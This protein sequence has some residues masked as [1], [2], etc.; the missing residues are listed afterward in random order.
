[1][2]PRADRIEELLRISRKESRAIVGLMS[3]TSLDGIDAALCTVSGSGTQTKVELHAFETLK[4]DPPLR[5]RL[6]ETMEDGKAVD[7]CEVDFLLGEALAE[8]VGSVVE[9]AGWRLADVDLIASHGQT[10]WHVD[11][12]H[13]GVPST[14]QVGQ[15][16]VIAERTGRIVVA[17][18]RPRDIAAGGAGAPLVA[19]VDHCLFSRPG[20][21]LLLQNVGGMANVTVVP[22]R[23]EDA[24]AF[25]TGPGN[26]LID[27]V[28]R[29]LTGDEEAC[30][31]DGSFSVLGEVDAGLLDSLLDHPYL[32]LPAPKTTGRE[33]FGPDMARGLIED[34]RERLID[35]VAT[36]VRFT[37]V[38]IARAYRELILPLHPPG[39][40]QETIVS[41][42]GARNPTLMAWL[43]DEL[44][45]DG[46]AVRSFDTLGVG[47]SA[48]AK[49]A[50]AFAVLANETIQGRPS[51]LPA[52]T[53][54]RRPAVLGK[55]VL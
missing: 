16:A 13:D 18:F 48:D 45:P 31:R 54:A 7:V 41:G 40:I 55:I 4:F 30:D 49:E 35:L 19:Y 28:C 11:R 53:G 1:V 5:R 14:L 27:E 52:A 47:F 26:V 21:T 39:T 24:L 8:S 33:V 37:A 23:A 20:R 22:E 46:V 38:S 9:A 15:P 51:N 10:L 36:L 32:K 42:G 17:D 44:A 50:V 12:T 34:Y 25:D 2:S 43:A 3:G 29:E 6:Q